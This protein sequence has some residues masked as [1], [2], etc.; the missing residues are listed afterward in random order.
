VYGKSYPSKLLVQSHRPYIRVCFSLKHDGHT[1]SSKRIGSQLLPS[2]H[3][4]SAGTKPGH[5][6]KLDRTPPQR[7]PRLR[8]GSFTSTCFIA[9]C[10]KTPKRI[11]WVRVAKHRRRHRPSGQKR[12]DH[13]CVRSIFCTE[14]IQSPRPGAGFFSHHQ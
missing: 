11:N 3:I 12:R 8:Q 7:S 10:H 2:S 14:K 6:S 9:W 4:Y 5:L 13:A 1:R